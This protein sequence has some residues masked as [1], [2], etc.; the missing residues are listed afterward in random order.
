MPRSTREN[1]ADPRRIRLW[2][3][4]ARAAREEL[5]VGYVKAIAQAA[6]AILPQ[7]SFS[8]TRTTILRLAGLRIGQHSL[9]QASVRLT[10]DDDL[11]KHVT[12]GK[13]TIVTGRLHLDLGATITIGNQVRIGHD[14]SLLTVSHEIGTEGQ[15]CAKAEF[16]PIEIGNGAWI[17]SRVVILPNVS[18]G[19]G[20]VV[21]AGAVVTRDVAP[22]TLVGGVP[23]RLIRV[24]TSDADRAKSVDA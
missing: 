23:A 10:G 13:G 19:A 1:S 11:H 8:R 17:A 6:S 15:R 9:F 3:R 16:G 24:L 5:H 12:V 7:N 22:N 4:L 2:P 21:A 14:V 18:I 20:A